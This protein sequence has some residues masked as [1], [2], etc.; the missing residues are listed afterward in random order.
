MFKAR[1][2]LYLQG[3]FEFLHG[4]VI[5][6]T[7]GIFPIPPARADCQRRYFQKGQPCLNILEH[8]SESAF[9]YPLAL[10]VE[11]DVE[12]VALLPLFGPSPIRG[13]SRGRGR[14][15]GRGRGHC[16]RYRS[17]QPSDDPPKA[18]LSTSSATHHTWAGGGG[19]EGGEY[20]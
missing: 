19:I 12:V 4:N 18:P 20:P 2:H 6:C 17:R 15:Q 7:C 5:R 3:F 13:C 16:R 14:G 11:V 1:H 9:P 10:D 8:R